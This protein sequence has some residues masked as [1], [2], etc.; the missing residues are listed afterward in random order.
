[1]IELQ[2][3]DQC[4]SPTVISSR[5]YLRAL[6][7]P[8]ILASLQMR[9]N[10]RTASI[11][12]CLPCCPQITVQCLQNVG[13]RLSLLLSCHAGCF[14]RRRLY[15]PPEL[16]GNCG[17]DRYATECHR[18]RLFIVRMGLLRR[19]LHR[20]LPKVVC[21]N[22]PFPSGLLQRRALKHVGRTRDAFNTTVAL[23]QWNIVGLSL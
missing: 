7:T 21:S 4:A 5:R 6:R 12:T 2:R 20:K 14:Y 19:V 22:T 3:C 18:G 17:I 1:M 10:T 13:T 9:D 11:T 8:A 16:R 15:D 23:V